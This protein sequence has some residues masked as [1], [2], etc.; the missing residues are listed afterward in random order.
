MS[1]LG[2]MAGLIP[3]VFVGGFAM[4]ISEKMLGET[5]P[6]RTGTRQRRSTRRTR[7]QSIPKFGNFRNVGF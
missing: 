2:D 5:K 1:A 7:R 3:L 4:K 6:L